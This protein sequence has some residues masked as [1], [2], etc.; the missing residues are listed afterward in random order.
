[1]ACWKG[2]CVFE[3]EAQFNGDQIKVKVVAGAKVTMIG[4]NAK[5]EAFAVESNLGGEKVQA[6]TTVGVNS[7]ALAEVNGTVE[8]DIDK[9]EGVNVGGGDL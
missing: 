8:L 3:G 6:I 4:G 9:S 2:G 1:M 5:I 7:S